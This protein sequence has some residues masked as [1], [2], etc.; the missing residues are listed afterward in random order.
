MKVT[1]TKPAKTKSWNPRD[2]FWWAVLLIA[3]VYHQLIVILFALPAAWFFVGM[4][5]Y[6]AVYGLV[7]WWMLRWVLGPNDD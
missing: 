1:V 4:L 5:G 2:R 3:V 7:V 6:C